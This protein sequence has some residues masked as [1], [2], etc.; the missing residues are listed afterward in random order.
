MPVFEMV[1][2][3]SCHGNISKIPDDV[4]LWDAPNFSDINKQVEPCYLLPRGDP[5]L[6]VHLP[7]HNINSKICGLIAFCIQFNLVR[8]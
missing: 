1:I 4:C 3:D 7:K 8:I 2:D 5:T 6:S